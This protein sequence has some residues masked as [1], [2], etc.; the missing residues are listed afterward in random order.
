MYMYVSTTDSVAEE[1]AT[2]R[3]HADSTRVAVTVCFNDQGEGQRKEW[4]ASFS[5]HSSGWCVEDQKSEMFN[6]STTVRACVRAAI[7]Q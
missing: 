7:L 6:S 3:N 4:C 2:V 1:V 5:L